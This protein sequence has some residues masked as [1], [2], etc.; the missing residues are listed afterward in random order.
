MLDEIYSLGGSGRGY[1]RNRRGEKS[2]RSYLTGTLDIDRITLICYLIFFD[3]NCDY[4]GQEF[5]IMPLNRE[6]LD[7]ILRECGFPNLHYEDDFDSFILEYLHADD[8]VDYLMECVTC[9]ALENKNFFLYNMYNKSFSN[10][11][12]WEKMLL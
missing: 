5:N 11:E 1:Q 8:P 2:I 6:R 12:Q 10:E 7:N 3:R 4:E 9:Y